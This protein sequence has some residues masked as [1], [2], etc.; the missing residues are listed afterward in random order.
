MQGGQPL[1]NTAGLVQREQGTG[2]GNRRGIEHQRLAVER[3]F[4]QRQAKAVFQQ[5]IEQAGVAEQLADAFTGGVTAIQRDQRRVGQQ[6]VAT[7]V[8][9]QYR[10]GHGGEQGVELQ[11][12][13]LAGKDIDH[14]HRLHAVDPKQRFAQLVEHLRAEGRGVDV[15]VGRHHLHGIQVEITP[16]EQR[17]NFLGDADTVDK[18]DMDTHG[19]EKT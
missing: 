1:T 6:Y 3:H 10:I 13:A 19:N 15:D 12:A 2:V 16:A 7:A 18:T 9:R 11:V 5:H 14:P 4:A 8:Q 17:Q